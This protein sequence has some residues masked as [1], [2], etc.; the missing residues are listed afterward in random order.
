[1]VGCCEL[2]RSLIKLVEILLLLSDL[3][4]RKMLNLVEIEFI[5]VFQRYESDAKTSSLPRVYSHLLIC[6]FSSP[7]TFSMEMEQK[8]L[9][10]N[11]LHISELI[12]LIEEVRANI[13]TAS[14]P[15]SSWTIHKKFRN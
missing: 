3:N 11:L 8:L 15:N 7:K 2:C 14:P 13:T 12:S 9:H 10:P 5:L 6:L 1:M 4:V